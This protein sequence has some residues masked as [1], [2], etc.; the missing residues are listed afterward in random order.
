MHLRRF[1]EKAALCVLTEHIIFNAEMYRL[2]RESVN[3][4]V[5]CTTKVLDIS[6]ILTDV[7]KV[8]RNEILH[9]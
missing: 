8:V 6:L 7:M 5:K 9:V 1:T 3:C 2:A 4:S